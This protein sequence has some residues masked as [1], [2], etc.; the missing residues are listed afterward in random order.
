MRARAPRP[1]AA[2]G[3]AHAPGTTPPDPAPAGTSPSGHVPGGTARS[4]PDPGDAAPSDSA[5]GGAALSSP[6]A[7]GTAP[8]D[9]AIAASGQA[10]AAPMETPPR[11]TGLELAGLRL[12]VAGRTVVPGLTLRVAPGEVVGLVGPNG[13]GKSTVLKALYRALR[14]RGGAVLIDGESMHGMRFRDSAAR[15]AALPQDERS[16]LDFLVAEVVRLGAAANPRLRAEE[17]GGDVRDAMARAGVA[18]LADRSVLGLS[19][20][21]RQRVLIARALAQRTPYLLLDEPTNHLDLRH[22]TDLLRTLRGTAGTGPAVLVALHDL[23]LAA[24]LCD[25]VVVLAEGRVVADAPPH[26]ALDPDTVERVYGVRPLLI[27]RPDTGTPH[28]LFPIDREDPS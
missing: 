10:T 4:V 25:R 2:W 13:C 24:A 3:R 18:D 17:L 19:G 14:P 26:E 15:I 16:E 23:N 5:V 9:Q 6:A 28:L 8:P 11:G 21:E 27:T 20:G 7:G 22:Q 1:R 12:D